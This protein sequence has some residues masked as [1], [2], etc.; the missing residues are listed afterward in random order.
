MLEMEH[1]F[2]PAVSIIGREGSTAEG[3]GFIARLWS[4][5]EA[6]YSEIAHLV[7]TDEHGTPCGFWGAM[8][9]TERTFAPWEAGFTRGLYLAGPQCRADAQ[10]PEGWRRW[11]L[12]ALECLRCKSEGM[13]TFHRGI[14]Y[15]EARGILLAAAVQ[16]FTDPATGQAYMFFPI[17]RV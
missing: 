8:S 7:D 6:H 12:P 1:I 15:L 11:D 3:E 5:L 9:D 14:A 4:E 16:D 10:A 17:G 13:E 2:M